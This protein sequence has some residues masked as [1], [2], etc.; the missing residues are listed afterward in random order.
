MD[1]PGEFWIYNNGLTILV[2]SYEAEGPDEDGTFRLTLSGLGIINGAQTTGS[3]GTISDVAARNL[4]DAKVLTRFV[5]CGDREVLAD[6]IRFNNTQNKVE[7][8]DFARFRPFRRGFLQR[9]RAQI[10]GSVGK[11]DN[12]IGIG[13]IEE[14]RIFSWRIKGKSKGAIK[15]GIGE[16]MNLISASQAS[17]DLDL[18][19]TAFANEHVAVRGSE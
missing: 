10:T 9:T 5:M 8:A 16:H 12:A 3:I 11:T 19:S 1:T 14:L 17:H 2:H 6:I 7:A 13:D 4:S 15:L 18:I